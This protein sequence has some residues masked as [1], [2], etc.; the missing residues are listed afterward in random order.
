[1]QETVNNILKNVF[2]DLSVEIR[3]VR[4]TSNLPDLTV[5]IKKDG[6]EMKLDDCCGSENVLINLCLRF[7]VLI[8]FKQ[9]KK[10]II[11]FMLCDE[12]IEKFDS[13]VSLQ[14]LDLFHKFIKLGYIKQLMII[15]HKKELLD[16]P[17]VNYIGV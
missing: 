13:E 1:M 9:F 15:S 4:P 2:G 12:G 16:L 14:I 5:L 3:T 17:N 7:G 10:T 11:D 6:N 8:V